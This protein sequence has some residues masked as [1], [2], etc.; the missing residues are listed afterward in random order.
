MRKI[1]IGIII[2]IIIVKTFT[3]NIIVDG[4]L[5][6]NFIL[7]RLKFKLFTFI[8][9]KTKRNNN[10]KIITKNKRNKNKIRYRKSKKG[11]SRY[12]KERK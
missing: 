10:N 2:I 7:N 11:K 3:L 8:N 12:R 4:R 1:T 5:I 6:F 9:R